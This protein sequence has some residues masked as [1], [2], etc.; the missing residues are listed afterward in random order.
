MGSGHECSGAFVAPEDGG[1]AVVDV[2]NGLRVGEMKM[3]WKVLYLS[4]G[5]DYVCGISRPKL[6]SIKTNCWLDIYFTYRVV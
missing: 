6:S 5:N 1:V 4:R 3:S 2:L